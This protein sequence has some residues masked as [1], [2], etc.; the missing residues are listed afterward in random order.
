MR[1]NSPAEH[2]LA[3]LAGS[4]E[5]VGVVG[6]TLGGGIGW[7]ARRYGVAC[8]SVLPAEARALQPRL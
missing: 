2:G 1:L 8:T 7:L 6:Y 4:A 5:D 3:A